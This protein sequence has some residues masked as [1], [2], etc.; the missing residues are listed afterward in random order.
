MSG[1]AAAAAAV[2]ATAL[3]LDNGVLGDV[4][5]F[6]GLLERVQAFGHEGVRGLGTHGGVFRDKGFT[7]MQEC[8]TRGVT[9]FGPT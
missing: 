9:C 3:L 7:P 5:V 6:G 1:A 8:R 4:A 2:A